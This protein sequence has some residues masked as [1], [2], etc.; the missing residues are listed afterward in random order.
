MR[1]HIAHTPWRSIVE[2]V[3]ADHERDQQPLE[4]RV[5]TDQ[6]QLACRL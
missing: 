3:I 6:N 2:G 4:H 5:A 1:A